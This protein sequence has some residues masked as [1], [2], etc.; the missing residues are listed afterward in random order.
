MRLQKKQKKSNNKT[1]EYLKAK[2]HVSLSI[3][4]CSPILVRWL[5]DA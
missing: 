1:M 4:P 5:G 3:S 2:S